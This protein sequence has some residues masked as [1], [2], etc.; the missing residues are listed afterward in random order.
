MVPKNEG[1]N[2]I[3]V[4]GR[5]CEVIFLWILTKLIVFKAFPNFVSVSL[6]DM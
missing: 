2:S 3:A 4:S 5:Y 6:Y 1:M